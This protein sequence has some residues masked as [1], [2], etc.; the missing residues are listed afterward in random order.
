MINMAEYV[1]LDHMAG[2][3]LDFLL[4]DWYHLNYPKK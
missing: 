4:N 3:V 2:F 1:S